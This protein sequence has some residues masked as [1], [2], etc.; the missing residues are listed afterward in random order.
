[1]TTPPEVDYTV[2]LV[3]PGFGAER[4]NAEAV[5]ESALDWLNTYKDEPG[6]RF[7][8]PVSAHLE[9]VAFADEAR[10][11]VEEDEGVATVLLHDLADDER[12]DLLRLCEARHVS[13]CYTVDV[14]RR[15]GPRKGPMKV[16]L[17]S[18]PAKGPRAHTLTAD[19]L[20]APVDEDEET[21]ARVGDVIAVRALGV[22]TH[23]W[24][25]SPPRRPF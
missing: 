6:F 19:T 18:E 24:H 13:A 12:D 15:P 9:I 5:V 14:P 20:T 21:G 10:A 7:A 17:R 23:H 25:K 2:V 11:R 22:M 3:F 1:M 4:E 8:P 16:V